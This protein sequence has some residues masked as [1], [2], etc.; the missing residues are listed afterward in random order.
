MLCIEEID[1]FIDDYCISKEAVLAVVDRMNIS[2]PFDIK[3]SNDTSFVFVCS[4]DYVYQYFKNK[5]VPLRIVQLLSSLNRDITNKY[6][7]VSFDLNRYISNYVSFLPANDIIIWKKV[8]PLNSFTVEK[9]AK[10]IKDN[11]HKLLWDIS[12]ALYGIHINNLF[13][14]DARIDNIGI[15]DGNF[16]LFDFDGTS[17][18]EHNVYKKDYY[19][20]ITSIIFN[21]PCLKNEISHLQNSTNLM[22]DIFSVF[23]GSVE[24]LE[25]LE[26]NL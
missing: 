6:L 2:S 1:N 15:R 26:I 7:G 21:T 9:K 16:V 5:N 18:D 12:K 3:S 13:H 4:S 25:S 11:L 8:T 22:D 10:I 19:D 17:I 20:L 14:G 23:D 24:D